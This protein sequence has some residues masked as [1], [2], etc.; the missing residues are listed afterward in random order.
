MKYKSTLDYIKGNQEY[1][2]DFDKKYKFIS[3]GEEFASTIEKSNPS[4]PKFH[5]YPNSG[6]LNDPNGLHKD[7][8]E[9]YIYYQLSPIAPY[10]L[11]KHWGLYKTKDF[12]KYKDEG[13]VI[14]PNAEFDKQGVF[15]GAAINNDG[16]VNIFY[17][18]NLK[19]PGAKDLDR[20]A[21]TV[22]Y[23]KLT[24]EKTFLFDV[25]KEIYH[26]HF[27]DPFPF[28]KNERKYLLNGAM[29][30]GEKGTISIHESNDWIK[31]WK[32]LGSIDIDNLNDCWMIECPSLLNIN[33]KD[34]LIFSVMKSEQFKDKFPID[35]VVYSVGNLDIENLKFKN[36]EIKLVDY[37]Y[38]FYAP[39]LFNDGDRDIMIGWLGNTFHGE[40]L[41]ANLGFNGLLTIPREISINDNKLFQKPIAEFEELIGDEIKEDEIKDTFNL[42][43]K[44]NRSNFNLKFE[45]ESE[46]WFSMEYK[47][48]NFELNFENSSKNE[49]EFITKDNRAI[50]A[51]IKINDITISDIR[52]IFDTSLVEIFINNG[53]Y[54]VTQR[55]YLSGNKKLTSDMEFELREIKSIKI[56]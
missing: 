14:S 47:D 28:I 44:N 22:H 42:N 36:E 11:N 15:S 41:D 20:F 7:G 32:H 24:K 12:I 9:Y 56:N 23:N 30:K 33:D 51:L 8:D 2:D 48:N 50:P 34:L 27:R 43:V 55:I 18:G 16:N 5:L 4:M 17:T 37:G 54:A 21:T 29:L 3:I 10:H 53:E 31:D 35:P 52:V 19:E 45:N 49:K 39:Q 40:Y 38:D 26:G 6:L 25:D 13:I 46:E 1:L